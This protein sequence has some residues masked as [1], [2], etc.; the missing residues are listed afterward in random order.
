MFD[1]WDTFINFIPMKQQDKRPNM[2]VSL[3][4]RK[5]V[6][7]LAAHYEQSQSDVIERLAEKEC[8]SLKIPIQ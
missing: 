1:I 8:K 6:N 5:L 2:K 3:R 4:A 7:L